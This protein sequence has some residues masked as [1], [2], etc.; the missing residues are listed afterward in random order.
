MRRFRVNIVP[1]RSEVRNFELQIM[2]AGYIQRS[3]K[4]I[5]NRYTTIDPSSP[6]PMSMSVYDFM[7]SL[8]AALGVDFYCRFLPAK[9]TIERIGKR[10]QTD[11]LPISHL[12]S[13]SQP[14]T[15]S[16][17]H[18]STTPTHTQLTQQKQQAKHLL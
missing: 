14:S 5:D 6:K 10:R 13:H 3:S 15:T 12:S 9:L 17:H 11:S 16:T 2:L 7:I 8:F 4:L 1:H 18:H